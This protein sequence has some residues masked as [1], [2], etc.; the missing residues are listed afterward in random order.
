MLYENKG[1]C[2]LLDNNDRHSE[3]FGPEKIRNLVG[4]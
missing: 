4:A 2:M 3:L 1:I